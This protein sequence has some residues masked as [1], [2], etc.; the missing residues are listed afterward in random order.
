MKKTIKILSLIL[1]AFMGFAVVACSDD[2]NKESIETSQLPA[3]AIAFVG[4]FYP[5]TEIASVVKDTDN[6][7]VEYDVYLKSGDEITFDYDGE[8]V[9]VDA[10][11]GG[12]IPDGIAPATITDYIAANYPDNGINEIKKTRK[13]YRVELITGLEISFDSRG[14]YVKIFN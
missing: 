2:D 7:V 8:W 5:D 12:T 14:N 6:G 4:A 10:P 13:G 11:A 3:K 1:I 9:E